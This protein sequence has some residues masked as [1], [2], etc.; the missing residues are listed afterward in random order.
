VKEPGTW[1]TGSSMDMGNN[2]AR[3]RESFQRTPTRVVRGSGPLN[4]SRSSGR[5]GLLG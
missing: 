3:L 1:V 5:S 4:S 2:I